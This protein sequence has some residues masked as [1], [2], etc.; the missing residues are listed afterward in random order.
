M[1]LIFEESI[2]IASKVSDK[3]NKTKIRTMITSKAKQT[4]VHEKKKM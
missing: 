4:R 2:R 1:Q 3:K